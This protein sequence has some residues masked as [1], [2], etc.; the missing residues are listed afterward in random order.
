MDSI[1][2]GLQ[3]TA[4]FVYLDDIVIYASSLSEHKAKFNRLAERLRRANL[5]L[6]SSK[7]SFLRREVAYLGHVIS[8]EGVKPCPTKIS[9]VRNFP[10]PKNAK[11][12]REFL[13][14]AGYYRRFIDKFSH[15]AKPLT[16]LL[17][18]DT[19]FEWSAA[20]ERA[21]ETLRNV[22]CTEPVLRYPDFSET[23]HITTDPSGY[24]VGDILSQGQIGQDRPIAYASRLLHGA[25]LNYS[26]IEKECLAIIYAVR[27]FRPYVYG[28]FFNLITDHQPLVWMHSV[29]DP[30]SR[31]L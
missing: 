30:S 11:S 4:L 17:R 19:K 21:F 1:L 5:K 10:R 12:V 26:I 9:A 28:K 27:H 8:D 31:F 29:K 2:S 16:A 3:G 15:I 22:L 24:A 25:E 13:G 23:F 6:Q 18:K 20:Q 7:C 14:L